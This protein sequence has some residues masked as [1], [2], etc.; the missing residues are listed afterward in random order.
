[1]FVVIICKC[2]TIIKYY[3]IITFFEQYQYSVLKSSFSFSQSLH[4][5]LIHPTECD[6][7]DRGKDMD[8][9]VLNKLKQEMQKLADETKVYGIQ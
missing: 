9:L 3:C 1:M 7:G 4:R 6:S 8:Q 5:S 2:R